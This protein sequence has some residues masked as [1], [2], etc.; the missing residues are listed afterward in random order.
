MDLWDAGQ[1]VRLQVVTFRF[2]ERPCLNEEGTTGS[3]KTLKVGLWLPH[4]HAQVSKFTH[5]LTRT[6]TYTIRGETDGLQDG[7]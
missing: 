7:G 6:H 2:T 3:R 4:V 1:A 5:A